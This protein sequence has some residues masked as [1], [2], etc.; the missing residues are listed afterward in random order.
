LGSWRE[1]G[2]YLGRLVNKIDTASIGVEIDPA[3]EPANDPA[4]EIAGLLGW[5]SHDGGNSSTV[6][7]FALYLSP[8]SDGFSYMAYG[9]HCF[10]CSEPISSNV[11]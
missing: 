10:S 5:T 7:I 6:P 8:I 3:K 9:Q 2:D 1:A 11:G 4:L